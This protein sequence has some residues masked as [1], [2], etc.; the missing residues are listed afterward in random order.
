M[1]GRRLIV[2]KT[3]NKTLMMWGESEIEQEKIGELICIELPVGKYNDEFNKLKN[4]INSIKVKSFDTCELE[5]E[6]IEHIE[7][8]EEKLKEKGQ[9]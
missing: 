9:N 1:Q 8:E 2:D 3:N 7:T 5:F 6:L 4:G